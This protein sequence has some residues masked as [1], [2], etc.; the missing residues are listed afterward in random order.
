MEVKLNAMEVLKS[1]LQ[2]QLELLNLLSQP[3]EEIGGPPFGED[4]TEAF[5]LENTG[6]AEGG[7]L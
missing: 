1:L 2:K 7:L 3:K 6:I 4:K 5:G